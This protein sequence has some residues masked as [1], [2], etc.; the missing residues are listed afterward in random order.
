[1]SFSASAQSIQ[2][3][4]DAQ[5]TVNGREIPF[6]MEFSGAGAQ[7][8]GSFFN[9]DQKVTSNSGTADGD[10]LI[11]NFDY[12]AA[13]LTAKLSDG[14]L[15]GTYRRAAT[16]YPFQAHRFAPSP[17]T[18]DQVPA[19]AGLWDV[20]VA[21]S[22]GEKAWRFVVRQSGAEVSAAILRI[23]GDTGSLEG[24]WRGGKFVLSHFDGARPLLL[25]VTPQ[26]D[27]TLQLVQNGRTPMTAVRSTQA[28]AQ[29]LPEPTDPSRHTSV[30]DPTV[31]FHFAFPDL[32]GKI[33]SDTDPRFRGKVVIVAIGG[34]WCP[35][36]HDEAPFLVELYRRYHA[37]GLEI[38]SLSFEE[39]DQ[40][41]DP[42]RLRA[43]IRTYG[44]EYPV[45][46]PGEPS[47]L[48]AKLPQAVN[49]NSWPTTFFL[50]RDGLVRSVHAGFAGKASGEF[51]T[52]MR[53]DVT[54]LLERLLAEND[55]SDAPAP[56]RRRQ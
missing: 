15:T 36:C 42:A 52:E 53:N 14:K 49:L 25:E 54:R 38:V 41:K 13:R 29:G 56:I 22:K 18:E 32:S 24:S 6:R 51:H 27:G 1:M 43:F 37:Q 7:A 47:E 45:L 10:S 17:L 30:Q 34:S 55:L 12:Y 5:V 20:E 35:N 19:I 44:I 48:S 46:V 3:L 31:P 11:L 23:D 50:G 2:G 9:G 33:V 39:A 40:L 8:A 4:W 21:S 26:P 28:R 16:E